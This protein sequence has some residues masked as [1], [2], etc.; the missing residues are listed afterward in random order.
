VICLRNN[1]ACHWVVSRPLPFGLMQI[2]K[3]NFNQK[4]GQFPPHDHFLYLLQGVLVIFW[5]VPILD[6]PINN[7]L[8][9]NL[10]FLHSKKIQNIWG[11][12]E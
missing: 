11:L 4:L 6:K 12:K 8:F 7:V 1:T 2:L 5:W 9:Q 10:L 3:T